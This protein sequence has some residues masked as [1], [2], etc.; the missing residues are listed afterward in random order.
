MKSKYKFVVIHSDLMSD[1]QKQDVLVLWQSLCPKNFFNEFI[2]V[3]HSEFCELDL[4]QQDMLVIVDA[5]HTPLYAL[6]LFLSQNTD[7]LPMRGFHLTD[8][9]HKPN[10]EVRYFPNLKDHKIDVI[11][12]DHLS[13]HADSLTDSHL[14]LGSFC[15][16]LKWRKK[17]EQKF[18]YAYHAGVQKLTSNRG[19]LF[20]DRDGV[21]VLD[22]RYLFEPEKV[23]IKEGVV[24]LISRARAKGMFVF[25]VTNQSGVARGFFSTEQMNKCHQK[26]DELLA[27]QGVGLDEWFFCP[28][29]P[30]G[31]LSEFKKKSLLRK[32]L[33]GMLMQ[34]ALKYPISFKNSLMVG[35]NLSD[36]IDLRNFNVYLTQGLYAL[37]NAKSDVVRL[38]DILM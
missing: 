15:D 1:H 20:L 32:P 10:S 2:G 37:D 17:I 23:E 26:I 3:S 38:S 8:T 22:K 9:A 21:I 24:Q 18:S 35:D 7:K 34:A 13:Q 12:T 16:A 5:E 11:A 33:P 28:F 29:H 30:D 27:Q 31:A 36:Q 4:A 14:F 6:D 19:A 25:C